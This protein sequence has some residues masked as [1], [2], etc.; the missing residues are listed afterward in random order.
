MHA[1][2]L[3]LQFTSSCLSNVIAPI[4]EYSAVRSKLIIGFFT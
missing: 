1:E 2:Y 3:D 4:A